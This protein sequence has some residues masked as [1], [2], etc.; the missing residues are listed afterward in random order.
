MKSNILNKTIFCRDNIDVL[1]GINSECIDLI[2][3]D[4]PFNTK[5][6]FIAPIGTSAEG[7]SFKDIFTYE[8]LKEEWLEEIKEDHPRIHI[9]LSAVNQLEG[10]KSYNYCYLAYMAIR[11]IECHRVI[12]ETGSLYLHCDPTMSHYLKLLMDCIF[13][14]KSFRNEIIWH[15]HT[16]GNTKNWYVKN[17]DTL[18]FYAKSKESFFALPKEKRY[19]KSKSR[20]EGQHNLGHATKEFFKDDQ[21]IYQHV[22]MDNVWDIPYINSQSKERCGY[23]T[24]KPL[25]LLDR[26]I[27]ASSKEG[28]IVLDPFCGCA[29][30]CVAAEM[31]NRKWIGVD[32]SIKAYELVKQRMVKEIE[33]L[34]VDV[35]KDIN[36]LTSAPKRTDHSKVEKDMKFIYIISNEKYANE[37]KVGITNNPK[38]RLK[39]Y[40]IGD[41]DRGFKLEYEL[42]TPYYRN[43]EKHI[44]E[45]FENKHE[46]VS[47]KL[48]DIKKEI[49]AHHKKLES[50]N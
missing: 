13:G 38:A 47:G 46:W 27:K 42:A 24:Q 11:L 23:P 2:Y 50:S 36:F 44:H 34:W 31:A 12:K 30:T 28:D 4:P 37:Y 48:E 43:I 8:D 15:Y 40:Q 32:I 39:Q 17:S 3:L 45:T 7:A 26:I 33:V 18:L 22:N 19:T 49:K 9:L 20:T 16:S 6:E 10:K 29:T 14:E 41:P 35:D 25:A 5:K 21:G 1:R